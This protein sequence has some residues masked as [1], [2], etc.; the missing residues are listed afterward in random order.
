MMPGSGEVGGGLWLQKEQRTRRHRL[1]HMMCA[2]PRVH[3]EVNQDY[4]TEPKTMG[5]L[6]HACPAFIYATRRHTLL[7][8][9]RKA[10]A[11]PV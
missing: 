5:M 8:L 1:T 10:W 3:G 4:I 6:V 11:T 9:C 2:P 7:Q